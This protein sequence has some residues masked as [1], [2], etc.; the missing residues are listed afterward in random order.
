[1]PS[2][3][4]PCQVHHE[5]TRRRGLFYCFSTKHHGSGASDASQWIM[6]LE[7][8]DEFAIFD[9]ADWHDLA[10]PKGNL[11]GLRISGDAILDLGS[12]GEKVAKFWMAHE[13]QSWHG[14]PLYP[15]APQGP[16]NRRQ[17]PFPRDV[18]KRMENEGLLRPEQRRRLEKGDRRI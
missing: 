6:G 18:L 10:D 5:V 7:P 8:S 2:G 3:E 13:G 1:M 15:L 17:A 12:L 11:Y 9:Q 14:F 16:A 4:D